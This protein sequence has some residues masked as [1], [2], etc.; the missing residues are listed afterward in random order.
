MG[1]LL[2]LIVAIVIVVGYMFERKNHL[3]VKSIKQLDFKT[4]FIQATIMRIANI[5]VPSKDWSIHH[6]YQVFLRYL[7]NTDVEKF[8]RIKFY[9]AMFVVVLL[10][11]IQQTNIADSLNK[12]YNHVAF[13]VDAIY[14][15]REKG[16]TPEQAHEIYIEEQGFLRAYIEEGEAEKLKTMPKQRAEKR[17]YYDIRDKY[18]EKHNV[19]VEELANRIYYRIEAYNSTFEINRTVQLLI[20][21]FVYFIPE[22]YVALYNF[23]A[24]V[25]ARRELRFLKRLII[26]NGS[27]KPVDFMDLLKDLIEKSKYHKNMLKDIEDLNKRNY[28]DN[29]S[30]YKGYISRAK[31]INIK[32][33][34]EKL[35]EANNYDFDQAILNIKNEFELEK[36]VETRKIKKQVEMINMWGVV[37]FIVLILL[38]IGYMLQPW[39][40][41]YNFS[42]FNM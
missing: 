37:G 33:F 17:I 30:I 12:I 38:I 9:L 32:L 20:L 19:T 4:N 27:I 14:S 24:G 25:D 10:I 1:Y 6:K 42:D 28:I 34:Y 40:S 3:K 21:A 7:G 22:I 16:L 39:L 8:F 26:M 5:F 15:V 29:T 13:E 41:A 2:I 23:F 36:R 35:D 18:E 31:D 11:G